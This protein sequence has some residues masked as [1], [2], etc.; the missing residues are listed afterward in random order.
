MRKTAFFLGVA[1]MAFSPQE[2]AWALMVEQAS[3]NLPET[4]EA[5]R[6]QTKHLIAP[7]RS[8]P[9]G[10]MSAPGLPPPSMYD[11][12]AIRRRLIEHF[13]PYAPKQSAPQSK[14]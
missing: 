1:L 9:R 4:D 10:Q 14:K 6:W 12:D 13:A 11:D 3:A 8:S 7:M 5:V 2:L